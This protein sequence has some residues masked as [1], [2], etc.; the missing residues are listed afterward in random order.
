MYD[1]YIVVPIAKAQSSTHSTRN[2]LIVWQ[3]LCLPV[4]REN[5]ALP[6]MRYR[7]RNIARNDIVIIIKFIS[8]IGG[9]LCLI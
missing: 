7:L 4:K 5:D 9:K 2:S 3:R 8:W 6:L 1:G